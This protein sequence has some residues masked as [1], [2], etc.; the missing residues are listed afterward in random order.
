MVYLKEVGNLKNREYA[1]K[2]RVCLDL[3]DR[4]TGKVLDRV[5]G[6]NYVFQDMLSSL[7]RGASSGQ[8]FA[9]G[10]HDRG[11]SNLAMCLND[12]D[13]PINPKLAFLRGN[14]IGFGMPSL[15]SSGTTRGAFNAANQILA[16]VSDRSKI[17]WKFQYEFTPSQAVGTIR[18]VGLTSQYHGINWISKH[19]LTYASSQNLGILSQLHDARYAYS[20]QSNGVVTRDDKYTRTRLTVDISAI[21]NNTDTKFVGHAPRTG[22][23]YVWRNSATPANRRLFEFSDNTFQTLLNTYTNSNIILHTSFGFFF[24]YGNIMWQPSGTNTFNRCNFINNTLTVFT[25]PATTHPILTLNATTSNPQN[26]SI[27]DEFGIYSLGNWTATQE[28]GLLFSPDTES[29]IAFLNQFNSTGGAPL[30]HPLMQNSNIIASYTTNIA[31]GFG[32]IHL[33]HC[34]TTFLLPQ[35]FVKPADKGMTATY[36]LEVLL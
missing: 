13:A 24:V 19:G 17:R 33:G 16:D 3:T 12:S 2:S 6:E 18:N 35:P 4:H 5:E 29:I 30:L 21:V 14:T 25:L 31:T 7:E 20:I 32:L 36:E 1:T 27:A 26:G 15:G 22:R 34:H 8:F 28:R 11:I 23:Y 9:F 10:T